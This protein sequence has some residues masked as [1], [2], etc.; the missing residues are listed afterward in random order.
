M[1]TSDLETDRVIARGKAADAFDFDVLPL[2]FRL[3]MV[4]AANPAGPTLRADAT[5]AAKLLTLG[6]NAADARPVPAADRSVTLAGA[7]A[8]PLAAWLIPSQK[9]LIVAVTNQ[10]AKAAAGKLELDLE[11]LGLM[12][13]CN[14]ECIIISDVGTDKVLLKTTGMNRGKLLGLWKGQR[15]AEGRKTR[16]PHDEASISVPAGACAFFMVATQ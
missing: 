8:C 9:R 10:G 16:S 5:L 2:D 3:F 7:D 14:G 12:P 1:I 13:A 11:K 6:I 15:D 4:A